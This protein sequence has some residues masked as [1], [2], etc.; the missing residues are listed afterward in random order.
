YCRECHSICDAERCEI[1]SSP[2]RDA[3]II[4]VVENVQD[5]M[6]IENTQQFRGVYHVL[7]GVV[8]PLEGVGIQDLQIDSLIERVAKGDVK[9]VILALSP[10]IE[11]DTTNF[12]IFKRLQDKDLLISVIARGVAQ[13]DELQYADEVTLGRALVGR[14]PFK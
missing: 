9:E 12:Y 1:C 6:A 8:N 2:N 14:V 5:V 11:G 4:C 10:T 7:G 3:S 13:N